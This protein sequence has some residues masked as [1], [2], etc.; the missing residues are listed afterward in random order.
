MSPRTRI[1]LIVGAVAA[2]AAGSTVALAVITSSDEGSQ[3]E[4]ET[5]AGAPPLVLNLGVRVDA[6]A[7]ALRR[8]ERLLDR[9]Q[10]AAA[11]QVFARYDSPEAEVGA[12]IAEWPDSSLARIGELAREHPRNSLV[13]LHLGYANLWAGQD[14][15]AA[16]AWRRAA[17]AQ[18]D[19]PSAQR[20]DDA[21]HP[22]FPPGQPLF[23][24]S[25]RPPPG[26][27]RLEP[28]AQLAS[29]ERSARGNDARAK[30]LYGL[31]L[32][33]LGHRI[34]ARREYDAAAKLAPRDADAQVAAAVGRFDKSRPTEA[35][36]RLGPL[37]RRFPK[38][39]TVRFHLGLLLLWLAKNQPG[40]VDEAKRQ[41]RLAQQVEPGSRLAREAKRL[42]AGLEDVETNSS[43]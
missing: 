27:S 29:L 21:L 20:A 33:R 34:S 7:R 28:P 3:A 22:G 16:S 13:L 9:D 4:A 11:G 19:S 25:F 10:R 8:A 30:L 24:P 35:F 5:L 18:P 41:L 15:E 26:L 23:V 6:E 32:Q 2:V 14:D 43:E 12:A 36:S 1:L 31:A 42:L 40:S 39:A 37:T 17:R 38:K